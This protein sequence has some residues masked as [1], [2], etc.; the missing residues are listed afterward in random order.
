M[1]D[2]FLVLFAIN[3]V[4]IIACN[5]LAKAR[6]SKH[7]IFWTIMGILFGPLPILF[8]LWLNPAP[9]ASTVSHA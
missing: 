4:G 5:R 3:V 1:I 9:T 7:V 6:R 8:I 2:V